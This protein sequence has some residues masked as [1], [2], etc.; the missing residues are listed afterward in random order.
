MNWLQRIFDDKLVDDS[1]SSFGRQ[2]FSFHLSSH[3]LGVDDSFGI[4][5][6]KMTFYQQLIVLLVVQTVMAALAGALIYQFVLKEQKHT[7]IF[8]SATPTLVAFGI[9]FPFVTLEPI[10]LIDYLSIQNVGLRMLVLA[11]PCATTL[12]CLE[13]FFGFAPATARKSFKNYVVYSSCLMGIDFD[14]SKMQPIHTS[15]AFLKTQFMKLGR[16]YVSIIALMTALKP[17][18]YEFFE[19]DI[20]AGSMDHSLLGLLSWRHIVNNYLVALLLSTSLSQS[21][22]GVS[23]MYN[24]LYGY[25]TVE[26]VMN[27][28]L[29]SSSPSDFWGRRWNVLIHRGLKNGIYKPM[30]FHFGASPYIAVLATFVGSGLLH[31][32][33]NFVLF[34]SL[35]TLN[36]IFFGWNGFLIVSQY[37]VG[38]WHIFQWLSKKL[39]HFIVSILVVLTAVPLGHLFTGDWIKAGYFDHVNMGLPSIR[40]IH[41]F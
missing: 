13:A 28:I 34:S 5:L 40:K 15:M 7:S 12:R 4:F 31:E 27:P 26:V 10:Y 30:R 33:I 9:V 16:D 38:H 8:S 23:L 6:P 14:T 32:Y 25:Q 11:L 24:I 18:K 1:S 39:P 2:L 3:I 29:N 20:K 22:L 36:I 19:V 37:V 35:G 21:T 17:Q 41:D